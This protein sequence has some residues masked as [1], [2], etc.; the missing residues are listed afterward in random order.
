M[1]RF[2]DIHVET[3]GMYV[4]KDS[5]GITRYM[6]A[7]QMHGCPVSPPDFYAKQ[8]C[9]RVV[10]V[11]KQKEL[12]KMYFNAGDGFGAKLL[13]SKGDERTRLTTIDDELERL[14]RE[15]YDK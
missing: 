15:H 8:V 3:V 9:A 13:A 14:I 11:N 2:I 4:V 10:D 6:R 5:Q 7:P 12:C 1:L